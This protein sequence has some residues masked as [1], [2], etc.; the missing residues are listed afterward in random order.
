MLTYQLD[1]TSSEPLYIQIYQYIKSDII[2]GMFK[3]G[4]KLPSKRSLAQNLGVSIITVE[5]AYNQLLDEGYIKS[6]QKKGYFVDITID[7]N[8]IKQNKKTETIESDELD[9]ADENVAGELFPFSVWTKLM[10]D[11]MSHNQE[12]LLTKT[13]YKGVYEL[14]EAIAK[15]LKSYRNITVSP[16]QIIIGAGTEFLYMLI[17]LLFGDKYVFATENPGY[18]QINRIYKLFNIKCNHIP[19]EQDG[20]DIEF[21]KHTKSDI[22]HISPSH[23]FPTGAI[24]SIGKRYAIMS[25]A[26][27]SPD[28][29]IIEDD[30]DSEFRLS[31][32][33]VS[34]MFEIDITGK[35]I[36]LNTFSKSLTPTMRI[37]YMILP[38]KLLQRFSKNLGFYSCSVSNFEQY[39]LA[40]FINEG[41]FEKHINR[42][43]KYY[44]ECRANLFEKIKGCELFRGCEITGKNSGLH[45]TIKFSTDK[46]DEQILDCLTKYG[47][48]ARN[49]SDFYEEVPAENTKTFIFLYSD[50]KN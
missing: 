50:Y 27:E 39:T 10:R 4:E 25:W 2:S 45:C 42:M 23:H 7:E 13:N 6:I 41:Y 34:S 18:K 21:L 20:M 44:K 3:S 36:Y 5:N 31:G 30:Y 22:L 37:S 1:N 32:K 19:V 24:T 14:R 8:V 43:K 49:I 15:H 26:L 12:K 38:E 33:P 40:R 9:L 16:E 29:Y 46:N 28:R 48:C 35:V 11:E 17:I 47:F